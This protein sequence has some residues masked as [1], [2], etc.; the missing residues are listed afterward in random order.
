M[1]ITIRETRN[2]VSI[3]TTGAD[4]QRLLRA[5]ADSLAV[6]AFA[7]TSKPLADRSKSQRRATSALQPL[8]VRVALRPGER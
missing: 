4:A 7:V 1:S 6:E 2:G 3:R 5:V 8:S